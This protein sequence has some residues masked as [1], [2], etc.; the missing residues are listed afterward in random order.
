[1]RPGSARHAAVAEAQEWCSNDAP[2]NGN[3]DPLPPGSVGC[4]PRNDTTL[5]TGRFGRACLGARPLRESPTSPTVP[6][7]PEFEASGALVAPAVATGQSRSLVGRK[8]HVKGV[9]T[10]QVRPRNGRL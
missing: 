5:I 10:G 9:L 2:P 3:P 1:V 6:Y 8:Y 4:S 7:V